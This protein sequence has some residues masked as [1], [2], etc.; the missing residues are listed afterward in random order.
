MLFFQE[1]TVNIHTCS[2]EIHRSNL[3]T[4]HTASTWRIFF[5]ILPQSSSFHAHMH[6]ACS[7]DHI[8]PYLQ[9]AIQ[10]A[11]NDQDFFT[12]LSLHVN[13]FTTIPIMDS[14]PSSPSPGIPGREL[15]E[16]GINLQKLKNQKKLCRI[17][18]KPAQHH[19]AISPVFFFLLSSGR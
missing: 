15:A 16:T 5:F 1:R 6:I 4:N 13:Q 10:T 14:I 19:S 7:E 2:E 17:F 11:E 3:Q 12:S 18:H 9:T 8:H